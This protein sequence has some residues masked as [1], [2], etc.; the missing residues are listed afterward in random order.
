[1][2]LYAVTVIETDDKNDVGVETMPCNAL[3]RSCSTLRNHL[4]RRHVIIERVQRRPALT[5][6]RLQRS[7]QQGPSMLYDRPFE[8]VKNTWRGKRSGPNRLST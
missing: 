4:T 3:V 1:M 6:V 5:A 8:T 2:D 7:C